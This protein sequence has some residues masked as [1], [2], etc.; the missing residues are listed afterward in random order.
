MT[1]GR[2]VLERR[3]LGCHEHH[4]QG[5]GTQTASDLGGFGTRAWVRGL[6]ENPKVPAYFGKVPQC[7]GMVEWK[8]SSK[9]KGEQLDAVADF[10]ASFATIPAD[11]TPNEWLD[12]PEVS[13]H[14]GNA[15]FQKEC[16]TCHVVD[17]LTEGGTRDAPNLFAWGSPRWMARMIRKPGAADRYGYLE[18]EQKMPAFGPDQLTSNDLETLIRY[19]KDDY[20]KGG[21]AQSDAGE[22][23][24]ARGDSSTRPSAP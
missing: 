4:S 19:L 10:V 14:P 5:S 22:S 23:L 21:S 7:D 8:R 9:L 24:A 15:P 16:G 3:C 20:P 6:L 17:G 13:D 2:A 12:R 1:Q 11:L 18:Q